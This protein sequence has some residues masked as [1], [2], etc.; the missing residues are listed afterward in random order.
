MRLTRK[1]RKKIEQ[2]IKEKEQEL[3]KLKDRILAKPKVGRPKRKVPP[4]SPPPKKKAIV[5]EK[6]IE[7]I[8]EE[9]VVDPIDPF[10]ADK[11][12]RDLNA[13]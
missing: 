13:H 5:M 7:K 2:Q 4:V 1:K 11:L 12:V 8:P 6:K 10:P 3:K 9:P